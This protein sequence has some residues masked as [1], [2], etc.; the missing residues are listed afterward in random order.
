MGSKRKLVRLLPMFA[1]ML[2]LY[3]RRLQEELAGFVAFFAE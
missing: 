2:Y 1:F 3:N